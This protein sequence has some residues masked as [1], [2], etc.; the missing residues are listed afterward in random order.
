MTPDNKSLL[1]VNIHPF[2]QALVVLG[3][4]IVLMVLSKFMP[5]S[6]YSKTS[7]LMPWVAMCGSVLFYALANSV[8]GLS[9]SSYPLYWMHS[10]IG[11][12]GLLIVGGLIAWQM[13]GVGIY[14]AGS[15]SWIYVVFTLG[16]LVFLSIVNLIKFFVFLAERSDKRLRGEE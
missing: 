12:A 4:A 11:F 13:S 8:L 3:L 15:V 5:V 6:P 9:A 2:R 1:D 10:I 14:D 16:Y 7:H